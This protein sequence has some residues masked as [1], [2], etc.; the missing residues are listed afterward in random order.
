M[1]RRLLPLFLFPVLLGADVRLPALLSDHALLQR[2]LPIHV[3]GWADPGETVSASFNGSSAA[4]TAAADGK[5]S[6]Y[7]KPQQAGG[8]HELT[9]QGE[10]KVTVRD[11][12][13]GDVWVGSGQSNMV[14]SVERS[15]NAEKEIAAADY[16]K[17]RIFQVAQETSFIEKEDVDGAWS[18]VTPDSIP[19]FSAVGYFFARHLHEKT[20]MPMGVIQS[21][22][23][24]T[25][26]EAWTSSETLMRDPALRQ[27]LSDWQEVEAAY[28]RAMARHRAAIGRWETA[29][30]KGARPREP[31]GPG[32][33]HQPAGLFNGMIAPLIPF[34]IRG[35]I[36]YQ[37]ENNAGR[38]QGYEYRHLFQTMIQ[39][40]RRRWGIG[41]F[42]F[43]WVQLANYGRVSESAQWAELREAQSMALSLR[44]T[45]QAVTID[46]GESQ[47]IH[48]KNKQDVGLRLALAA[49]AVAYG[50]HGLVYSGPVCRQMT[51]EGA[52]ARLWFNHTGSGLVLKNGSAG[53]EIAGP[54]G[55]FHPAQAEVEGFTLLVSSP[56]VDRPAAVRYAWAADPEI[57]LFNEEGLPASP[58]RTDDWR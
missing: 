18:A 36:W 3:W 24:G 12:L 9:V 34:A 23:G 43:F 46:I 29:G 4:T 53:F 14:W 39:D 27:F 16:P 32:H 1:V 20:D 55:E 11:V 6:L 56:K 2:D 48:P 10:N 7:L 17:I 15:N 42:P 38:A 28:P 13:V 45:G 51:T 47:D 44:E 35:V 52:K 22:W 41:D 40:W 57:T 25:P 26:A 37:G 21:A 31:R 30:R 33:Q 50:E 5:F 58:F 49:R 19:G 8:P 54:D